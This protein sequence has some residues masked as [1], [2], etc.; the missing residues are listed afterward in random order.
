MREAS[1][2]KEIAG[3]VLTFIFADDDGFLHFLS[4]HFPRNSHFSYIYV[5]SFSVVY[6]SPH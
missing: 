3:K 4:F 1:R 5:L 2:V 6:F